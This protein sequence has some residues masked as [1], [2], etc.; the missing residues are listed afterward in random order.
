MSRYMPAATPTS[1][2]TRVSH[3]AVES[4]PSSHFPPRKN[5]TTH[6]PNSKPAVA[7]LPQPTASLALRSQGSVGR[8][9][10]GGRGSGMGSRSLGRRRPASFVSRPPLQGHSG[11]TSQ[12]PYS[13][14]RARGRG[15][16][17]RN[18]PPVSRPLQRLVRLL[19]FGG[20]LLVELLGRSLPSAAIPVVARA[21]G[22]LWR[23]LDRGRRALVAENLRIAFG[24]TLPKRERR[25]LERAA[26]SALIQVVLEV[27]VQPRLLRSPEDLERRVRLHG[28][29]REMADDVRKGRGGLLVTGHLGNW[30]LGG[31]CLRL[32]GVP[33]RAVMRSFENPLLDAHAVRVRGGPDSVIP[34]RGAVSAVRQAIAAG[35]WVGLLSD[36][37]AGRSGVFVPFFG[38]P[39]S[40]HPLPAALA[41]RMQVPLYVAACL[42]RTPASYL[43]DVHVRRIDTGPAGAAL[44]DARVDDVVARLT[45]T[46]EEWVRRAPDQYNWLHRRWKSRP[47][48]EAPGPHQP[49]Y[50]VPFEAPG[51]SGTGAFRRRLL[52]R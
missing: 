25:R 31:R 40:T 43:F 3:G 16:R 52:R 37:N 36:Q 1:V 24:E 33:A 8:L 6:A 28:D 34:K 41:I 48:G 14:T 5:R 47:P 46:I 32:Y 27:L 44:T 42:R 39:A 35:S 10:S 45:A 21:V 23:A 30:E 15:T 26:F 50:G 11:E 9:Y 4:L 22:G 38:L 12:A 29:W 51:R 2:P 49:A 17:G 18:L 19:Q 13:R 7:Q 20:F